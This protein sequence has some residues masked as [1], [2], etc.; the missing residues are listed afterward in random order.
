[1]MLDGLYQDEVWTDAAGRELRIVDMEISY[2]R[3][4]VA[5][6]ERRAPHIALRAGFAQAS[7]PLPDEDTAAYDLV[8]EVLDREWQQQ[9][10]DPVGW[11]NDT[12]LVRA[13]RYRFEGDARHTPF[14]CRWCGIPQ[15]GHG[16]QWTEPAG[17]HQWV[18]PTAE[19]IK[20]RMLDRRARRGGEVS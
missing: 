9:S 12:P 4:V 17:W 14:G 19:Q 13:L 6:L 5:W 3:N 2:C 20:M 16:R 11:L 15:R 18:Q 1:M 7:G 8:S 10:D